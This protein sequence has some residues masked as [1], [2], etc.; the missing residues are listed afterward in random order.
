MRRVR[1]FFDI[2]IQCLNL[3]Y[4]IAIDGSFD[5]DLSKHSIETVK[6]NLTRRVIYNAALWQADENSYLMLENIVQYVL[7][8]NIP[9]QLPPHAQP[10]SSKTKTLSIKTFTSSRDGVGRRLLVGGAEALRQ[11][12]RAAAA[13][14]NSVG[15]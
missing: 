4:R 14:T 7:P 11:R 13:R 1:S 5:A 15:G 8:I 9:W 12:P 2:S 10:I 6:N 3:F